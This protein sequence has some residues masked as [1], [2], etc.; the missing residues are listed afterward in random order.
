[1]N[2][3]ILTAFPFLAPLGVF[4]YLLIGVLALWTLV[5]KGIALWKSARN[6]HTKWF[7]IMMVVN[8]LGILE[9]IYIIRF[10]KSEMSTAP[11]PVAAPVVPTSSDV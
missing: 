4:A 5:I 8:T 9:L 3:D 7:I 6:S 11:A 1:M 2:Y 10:S